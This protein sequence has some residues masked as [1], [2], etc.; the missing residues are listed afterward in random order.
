MTD[1]RAAEVNKICMTIVL[2]KSAGQNIG[3]HLGVL[4]LRLSEF[5]RG[6][7]RVDLMQFWNTRDNDFDH[8]AMY[9]RGKAFAIESSRR[10]VL[11]TR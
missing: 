5:Y 10:V 4:G 11:P 6:H 9:A 8:V 1:H 7:C 2:Q 3:C